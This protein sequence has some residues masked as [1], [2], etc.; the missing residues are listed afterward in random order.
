MNI[1]LPAGLDSVANS[2]S[3]LKLRGGLAGK[4]CHV[5]IFFFVG[6]AVVSW[7][8]QVVWVAAAGL[9]ASFVLAFVMLWRL[10]NLA[11][12][13][14]QS[15]LMEGAEFLLHE[16]LKIAQKGLPEVAVDPA[17]VVQIAPLVLSESEQRLLNSPDQEETKPLPGTNQTGKEG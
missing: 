3:N 11:D 12:K 7:S 10:I 6:V 1:N 13:N 15:A 14:P 8:V 4:I 16:H 17:E 9:A 2:V 5:L